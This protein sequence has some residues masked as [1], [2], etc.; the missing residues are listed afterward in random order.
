MRPK[1]LETETVAVF[2]VCARCLLPPPHRRLTSR[3]SRPRCTVTQ[4]LFPDRV[5]WVSGYTLH[6]YVYW[7]APTAVAAMA[8]PRSL[9]FCRAGDLAGAVFS[10]LDFGLEGA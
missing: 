5:L 2:F 8:S 3:S 7:V 10:S 9:L 4:A 1:R 6:N